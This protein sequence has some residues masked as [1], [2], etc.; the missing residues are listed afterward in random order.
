MRNGDTQ[1]S[2]SFREPVLTSRSW[3]T[4]LADTIA[5]LLSQGKSPKALLS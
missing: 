3:I 5:P 4:P 1:V 2:S